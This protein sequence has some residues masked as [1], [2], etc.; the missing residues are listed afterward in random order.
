MSVLL[1]IPWPSS[2]IRAALKRARCTAGEMAVEATKVLKPD[3]LIG[4]VV[5]GAMSGIEAAIRIHEIVPACRVILFSGQAATADL[6]Q[7]A[8]S[9][10]HAFEIFAKPVHPQ[11]LLVHLRGSA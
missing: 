2:S 11:I 10:G 7:R 4:D 1:P 5:M 8:R 6:A 3:V 9:E